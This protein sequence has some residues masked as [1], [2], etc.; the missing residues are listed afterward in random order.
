MDRLV[1][2]LH[3]NQIQH[4]ALVVFDPA[5]EEDV[6]AVHVD[7]LVSKGNYGSA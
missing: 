1:P 4:L 7:V 2:A 3:M 5:R 6:S